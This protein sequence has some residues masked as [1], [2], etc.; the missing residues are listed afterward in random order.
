MEEQEKEVRRIPIRSFI[1][2]KKSNFREVVY[3]PIRDTVRWKELLQYNLP[4]KWKI[5]KPEAIISITGICHQFHIKDKCYFKRD[6]INAVTS[7]G[8]W[9]VTCGLESGVVQFI[10]DAVNEHIALKDCHIPIVGLLSKRISAP[11]DTIVKKGM[12]GKWVDIPTLST[13][14]TLDPNH[15]QFIFLEGKRTQKMLHSNAE[16]HTEITEVCK[17]DI[18]YTETDTCEILPLVLVL[19]EGG[20]SAL[21]TVWGVLKNGNPVVVIDGS[22]GAADFLAYFY[23]RATRESNEEK[24]KL[25]DSAESIQEVIDKCFE[26]NCKTVVSLL[27]SCLE[28]YK[29]V[30]LNKIKS[31]TTSSEAENILTYDKKDNAGIEHRNTTDKVDEK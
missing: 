15:T 14:E 26:E 30:G 8:S 13:Q 28:N 24:G 3:I 18:Q 4:E 1:L 29:L 31:I 20:V 23:R 22:G 6:L 9:I 25:S 5:N 2:K 17:T 12:N 27:R 21:E 7:T 19:I 10:E 11:D 16:K